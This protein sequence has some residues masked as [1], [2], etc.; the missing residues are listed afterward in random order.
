MIVASN[1][2]LQIGSIVNDMLFKGK[3][4]LA[5]LDHPF[6]VARVATKE[7]WLIDQEHPA[8]EAALAEKTGHRWF[9]EVQTD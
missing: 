1:K 2:E 7:E 8:L 6:F 3:D 5:I 9:Y 4:D